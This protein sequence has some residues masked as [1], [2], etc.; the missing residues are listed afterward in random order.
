[1]FSVGLVGDYFR[2]TVRR[3]FDIRI[4]IQYVIHIYVYRTY[5]YTHIYIYVGISG[6]TDSSAQDKLPVTTSTSLLWRWVHATEVQV[7]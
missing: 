3:G 5:I 6:R 1:M 2:C 4:N 7:S